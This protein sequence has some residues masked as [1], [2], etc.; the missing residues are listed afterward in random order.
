LIANP[1]VATARLIQ[2]CRGTATG[3]GAGEDTGAPVLSIGGAEVIA[4]L[5]S[6]AV[7]RL[8]RGGSLEC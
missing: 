5:A 4:L 6:V 8:V 3:A 1:R 2:A 7:R